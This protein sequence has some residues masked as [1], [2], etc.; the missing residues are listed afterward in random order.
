MSNTGGKG[1]FAI[2]GEV[3]GGR[4]IQIAEASISLPPTLTPTSRLQSKSDK[5]RSAKFKC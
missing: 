1:G 4:V 2:L 3:G 5:F